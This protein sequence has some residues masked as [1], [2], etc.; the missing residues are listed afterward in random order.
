MHAR[1]LSTLY[2]LAIELEWPKNQLYRYA[3]GDV[4]MGPIRME[5][6]ADKTGIPIEVIVRS[7][8]KDERARK[9]N[10]TKGSADKV[11]KKSC[12]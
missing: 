1:G 3:A 9:K 11:P 8:A 4:L 5:D 2:Q 12:K 6:F 7:A 10:Q